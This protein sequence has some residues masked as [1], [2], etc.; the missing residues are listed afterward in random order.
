MTVIRRLEMVVRQ[1][2][3]IQ[4]ILPHPTVPSTFV[5]EMDARWM[6]FG[7]YVALVEQIL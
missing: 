1:F 3:Y 5:E 4:T 2:R 6:Q 7:D